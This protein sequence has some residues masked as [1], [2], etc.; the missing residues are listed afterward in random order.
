MKLKTLLKV[1]LLGS[2]IA[3][4]MPPA[5]SGSKPFRSCAVHHLVL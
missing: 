5:L 4:A 1:A 2:A 3:I